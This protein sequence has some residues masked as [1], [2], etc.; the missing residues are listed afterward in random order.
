MRSRIIEAIGLILLGAASRLIPHQPN[1]TAIGAVALKSRARFGRI[2]VAIPLTS[3]LLTD[4][5]IGFYNWKLLLSVYASFAVI[6]MLG[7]FLT[8]ASAPR[9]IAFSS[10]G[11]L[12]FFFITNTVVWAAS[13]WYPHDIFGLLACY[14]AGLPF[15]YPMLAGDIL[16]SLALFKFGDAKITLLQPLSVS[17][18]NP[19]IP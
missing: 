19:A 18:S 3:M 7:A 6:S 17:Y 15:L 10:L 5:L 16:F 9:I 11:S 4:A 13:S 1:T 8:R 14:A 12:L 2:G